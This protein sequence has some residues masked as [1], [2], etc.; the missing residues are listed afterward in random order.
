[1]DHSISEVQQGGLRSEF[2]W[3]IAGA[4]QLQNFTASLLD[5]SMECNS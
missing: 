2:G 4:K 1:M 5:F 3:V